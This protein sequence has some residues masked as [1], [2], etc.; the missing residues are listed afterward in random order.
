MISAPTIW[1]RTILAKNGLQP[2]DD[3]LAKLESYVGML[4]DWNTKVN[5]ISRKDTEHIWQAHVL[6]SASILIH[7]RFPPKAALLDLGSGGGL[8]GVVIKLL[9]PD[10]SVTCLD[11]TM[12]KM[13]AVADMIGRLGLTDCS[14]AWGRAEDLNRTAPLTGSFDFVVARAVAPLR[15]LARWSRPFFRRPSGTPDHTPTLVTLKGGDL[16][17]EC[18]QTKALPWVRTITASALSFPGSE[19]IPGV[20]KKIVIVEFE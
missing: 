19:A 1:L 5:L 17:K 14:T 12:K 8:P 20:D 4:L 9:R 11:A 7:Y 16:E 3:Q 18:A 15:D 6:H 2:T 10:L 13:D